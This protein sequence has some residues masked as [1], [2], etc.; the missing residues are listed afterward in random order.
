MYHFTE[1]GLDN[2]YLR[3]GFDEV[4]TAEGRAV[5]IHALEQLHRVIAEGIVNKAGFLTGKELRF[6]R[7]ELDLSQKALGDLM[8][9]SDQMVAKWEKGESAIPI[10]AD[11]AVR[12]LYMESIGKGAIAGLL[13][14]L[15]QLDRQ[16]HELKYELEET[17][18]GWTLKTSAA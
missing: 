7:I 11:K 9:K 3:N 16:Y 17:R 12:D 8:G 18:E 2:I 13:K 14:E 1:C 6:L 10:L 5:G 4:E 15:S